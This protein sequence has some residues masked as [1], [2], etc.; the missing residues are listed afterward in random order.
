MLGFDYDFNAIENESDPL[1]NAYKEMFEI[2][3]SQGHFFRFMLNIYVPYLSS[4][5][6]STLSLRSSIP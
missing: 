3:V 5:F 2:S 1:L 6:V 4:L